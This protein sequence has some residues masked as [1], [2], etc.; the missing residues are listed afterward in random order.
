MWKQQRNTVLKIRV[1]S[2]FQIKKKG[3]EKAE[4]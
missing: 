3:Y 1:Q 2:E 4:D